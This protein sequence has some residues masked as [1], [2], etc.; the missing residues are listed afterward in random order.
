MLKVVLSKFIRFF[1]RLLAKIIYLLIPIVSR[2]LIILRIHSRI[3]NQLNKIRSLVHEIDDHTKLISRLLLDNKLVALDVGAQGG[4]FSA[5]IFPKKYNNFFLPIVVEPLKSEAEKLVKQNYQV[6]PKGLWSTNCKK[7]IYVLG[8]RSGSSS[9]YKPMKSSFELYNFKKKSFPLFDITKEEEIDCT[10][11]KDSL[12]NL[13]IKHLDFLKIDTQGSELEILK[14]MGEYF[15]LMM[16]IEAQ[17]FPMYDKVP[18]WGELINYLYKKDYMVCEFIEIGSHSTRS[19]VEMDLIFIP[20][21]LTEI[22]RKTI[23]SREK[24]F[25]SLM[26]I[27]GQI[28][29]LQ[30]ISAKLN[31]SINTELQKLKD[32]FFN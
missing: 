29:L 4:F 16:K 21:Y 13:S 20:N 25:V 10:T 18:N 31:L 1:Y 28:K 27:F 6:I 3:I 17:I 19:P 32:K 11:I 15:P 26:L 14:G 12:N 24:K 8:K 5:N 9:M 23:L 30:I 7:K 22:G 2:I